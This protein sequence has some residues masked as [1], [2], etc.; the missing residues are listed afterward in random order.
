VSA[1]TS[2]TNGHAMPQGFTTQAEREQQAEAIR[3]QRQADAEKRRREEEKQARERAAWKA[4]AAYWDGLTKEEQAAHDAAAIAQASAEELKL[5]EPGPMR[6]AGLVA[7][8]DSYTRKLLQAQGK[9]PS[10]ET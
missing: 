1:I 7:L 10:A 8:R 3:Q 6:R 4:I 5:I 9:L 2:G